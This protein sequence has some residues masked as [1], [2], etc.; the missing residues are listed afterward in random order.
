MMKKIWFC[1]L[2]M[3]CIALP[4]FAHGQEETSEGTVGEILEV[5][6]PGLQLGDQAPDFEALTHEGKPFKFSNSYSQRPVLLIF[7]RGGW[8]PYCNLHLQA[9]Q[10]KIKEFEGLGVSVVAV[11][12]DKPEKA[13]QTVQEKTLTFDVISNADAQVL[14]NYKLVH[15]I[16][17]ELAAKYK[18]EYNIDLEAASGETHHIVAIPAVYVVNKIGKI[19][20]AFANEDYTVRKNPQELLVALEDLLLL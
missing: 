15:E 20:Y 10:S 9:V 19:I 8:C 17:V 16:P 3:A 4:V 12:V 6:M 5:T 2:W 1:V 18:N 7:Y 13:A 11:S 14:K